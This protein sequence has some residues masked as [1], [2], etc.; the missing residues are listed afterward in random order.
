[1]GLLQGEDMLA[2]Q[3]NRM[4]R[5]L[6]NQLRENVELESGLRDGLDQRSDWTQLPW[7]EL[8]SRISVMN[9]GSRFLEDFRE[10]L[11][12]FM[13]IT[14][15]GQ[16]LIDQ[17]P[18]LLHT[19]VEL[20]S[21]VDSSGEKPETKGDADAAEFE[22]RLLDSVG[23]GRQDEAREV[24]RLAR[25]SWRLR[26]DDNILVARLESQLL[27]ALQ[28]AASRLQQ[29]GRLSPDATA[30]VEAAEAIAAALRDPWIDPVIIPPAEADK[31]STRTSNTREMPRQLIG[32]PA[33]PG[34]ATGTVR[35]IRQPQ[36]LGAFHAGEVLVC[37]AIQPMMTHVVPL[38]AAVV[39][40]RG[41]MLIH[42]AII[43]RELGIPCV[44][45]VPEA[46]EQLA[47][48]QRVTVDGYLGLVTI[49][50]PEFDLELG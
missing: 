14:F 26:D 48:G 34:F 41:G 19:V 35:V 18:Q 15:S 39:E 42:G 37:D 47:E 23:P 25:L 32:Q 50:E 1:V 46:A 40:R 5:S 44:N 43:A 49:G 10:L 21:K 4:L 38:A 13:D 12:Q 22:Q 11:Q 16:R 31:V 30:S 27:R 45:G 20:A 7:S 8:E 29:A 36:D 33:A 2:V 6:A 9:G 28:I 24:I 17:A 3:R